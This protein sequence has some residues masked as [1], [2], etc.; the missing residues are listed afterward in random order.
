MTNTN[1]AHLGKAE[2]AARVEQ[3]HRV[4]CA[5][6]FTGAAECTCGHA[7]AEEALESLG[8]AGVAT[9]SLFD[10]VKA[11]DS[12]YVEAMEAVEVGFGHFVDASA[13]QD[14]LRL[15]CCDD[16]DFHF[17]DQQVALLAT[18]EVMAID[19]PTDPDDSGTTYRLL[20]TVQRP[21]TVDD[22]MAKA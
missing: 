22:L 11:A 15:S 17:E 7:D 13:N 2:L 14:Q 21:L 1:S 20:L 9:Y 12:V 6:R 18:G 19:C 8:G 10:L 16:T 5:K 3:G 4:D